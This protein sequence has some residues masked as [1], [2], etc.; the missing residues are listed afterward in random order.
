MSENTTRYLKMFAHVRFSFR[1]RLD[2]VV[3]EGAV[4][5]RGDASIVDYGFEQVNVWYVLSNS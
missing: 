1:G 4:D 3:F 5:W 2:G